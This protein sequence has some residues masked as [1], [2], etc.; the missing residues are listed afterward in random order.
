MF[1]KIREKYRQ[2]IAEAERKE[3]TAI[4]KSRI[5]WI[6]YTAGSIFLNAVVI[7]LSLCMAQTHLLASIIVISITIGSMAWLNLHSLTA[8]NKAKPMNC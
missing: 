2:V 7:F 1:D 8:Y 3:I 6:G 4:K 5:K